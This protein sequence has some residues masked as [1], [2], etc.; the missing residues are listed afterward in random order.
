MTQQT[1][2]SFEQERKAFQIEPVVY[3]DIA[4]RF[5]LVRDLKLGERIELVRR[6]VREYGVN[7]AY[8]GPKEVKHG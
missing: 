4:S 5:S 6:L 8:T 1:P 7:E 2:M 3:A